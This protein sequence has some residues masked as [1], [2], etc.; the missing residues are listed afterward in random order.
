MAAIGVFDARAAAAVK[1]ARRF[2]F[3]IILKSLP[4]T[5]ARPKLQA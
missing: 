1:E 5:F 4:A 3:E 2:F